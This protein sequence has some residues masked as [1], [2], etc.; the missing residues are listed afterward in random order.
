MPCPRRSTDV[1]ASKACHWSV[2]CYRKSSVESD[3]SRRTTSCSGPGVCCT[4]V[5]RR[6]RCR[7]SSWL[8]SPRNRARAP[9]SLAQ[10]RHLQIVEHD[11]AEVNK[12]VAISAVAD[13]L[14]GL[15]FEVLKDLTPS[16]SRGMKGQSTLRKS[17]SMIVGFSSRSTRSRA[18][19]NT[20]C[21][22]ATPA[23]AQ[24]RTGL[25]NLPGARRC[26]TGRGRRRCADARAPTV[27]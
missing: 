16:P 21:W 25:P 11:A 10:L 26:C 13:A 19:S 5:P 1:F 12:R 22:K 18:M 17:A 7:W 20:A 8:A 9:P 27:T 3:V 4:C 2:L 14:H 15:G 24:T 23:P 6:G